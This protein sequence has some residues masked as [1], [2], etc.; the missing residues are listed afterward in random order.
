[1]QNKQHLINTDICYHMAEPQNKNSI[2]SQ[3][4]IPKI[5]VLS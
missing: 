1:M 3:E 5:P 4:V 2:L